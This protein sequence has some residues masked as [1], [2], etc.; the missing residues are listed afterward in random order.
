VGKLAAGVAH[1]INNPLTAVL[2]FTHML[3]RRNDL[4]DE[5]RSDLETVAAQTERVR[6]IVKNLLDF[7]RQTALSPEPL[8]VNTLIEESV[9]LMENQA[10][11][12]GVDLSFSGDRDLPLFTL[13][14]NQCQSVL[15]NMIINALDATPAGGR[16][17][18]EA[19]QARHEGAQGVEIRISDTGSGIAPEHMDK[20]FDPFFTTKEVGKG[21]GLGLAVSSGIVQRHGG[22]IS[23]RSKPGRGTTFTVWLP[24][25]PAKAGED[26]P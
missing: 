17:E 24:H 25:H 8:N 21:T 19:G 23:V 15:I 5:V 4:P 6:K 9:K 14:H 16:I 7:S 11:I 3:M 18:I 10:L 22:A 2:T 26:G 12:K 20:L 1:E 13:D